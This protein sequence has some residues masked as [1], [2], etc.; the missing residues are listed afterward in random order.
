MLPAGFLV[1]RTGKEISGF[2]A[3]FGLENT[4]LGKPKYFLKVEEYDNLKELFVK[5]KNFWL[6][7]KVTPES[8]EYLQRINWAKYYFVKAY[9]TMYLRER[10]IFLSIALEALCGDG[11][12]E[13]KYRY[14]NRVALL[15]GDDLE[16]LRGVAKR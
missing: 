7:N 16:K 15:L 1:K 8:N 2:S 9:Q 11:Q 3:H 4:I 5:Y 12:G 10:Y 14:A 13:L 6:S